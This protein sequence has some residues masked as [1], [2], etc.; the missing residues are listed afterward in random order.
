MKKLTRFIKSA[1][2][3]ALLFSWNL[4]AQHAGPDLGIDPSSKDTEE[5][6]SSE[7]Y[8]DIRMKIL[9]LLAHPEHSQG[10]MAGHMTENSV[11]LQ[12]RLTLTNQ[13][14]N[15]DYIGCPGWACFEYSDALPMNEGRRTE[16]MEALPHNDYIIKTKVEGL[17][18]NTTYYYRLLYGK[19][20]DTFRTG[21]W[22]EFKTLPGPDISRSLSMVIMTCMNYSHFY[23][24]PGRKY[25]GIDRFNGYPAA[26]HV[27]QL[28]PDFYV[29]TGDNV[30]YDSPAMP[31]GN[32][33]DERSIRNYYHLQFS[34]PRLVE[35][36]ANIGTYWEKD[37]HDYRYN[38]ADTTGD[39][40]PSHKLGIRMFREQLPVVDPE[41]PDE[42][43]Y[44]TY[45][46]SRELQF[47]LVENRDYRSPNTMPDGP[48]KSI[49]GKEQKAW[50]KRTLKESDATFK[51]LISPNPLIGPDDA[52]KIDNHANL[53]GFRH[54]GQEF[55]DFL[56]EEGFG[57]NEFFIVN[58][59]RHWQYHSI[60]PR[61]YSEFGTG[62]FNDENARMGRNPGDPAST[63]PDAEIV[64][65]YT[66]PEPSGGF[67][68]V[69]VD[70]E[71][72][73]WETPRIIF[74]FYNDEGEILYSTFK[75]SPEEKP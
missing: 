42:V 53:K 30:Y 16:W 74:E 11:I 58:G 25:L 41:D 73:P 2:C 60:D 19:S 17:E 52:Y 8:G 47:W 18:P 64:Q 32:G 55:L 36:F 26:E 46:V 45:R 9:D 65:P 71:G 40:L 7:Q 35:L 31:F 14:F 13:Q 51:I 3:L 22:C 38:D 59:D 69:R 75:D 5:L 44:K 34:Q 43:T 61:G 29:G 48:D 28:K 10:E 70:P 57:R 62:A 66:S 72:S 49:W 27:L 15:T 54:E 12:T 21:R 37:D 4:N 67:L 20:T 23:H 1:V 39:R 63:D 6:I 50:L 24:R 33:I 68:N 56:V